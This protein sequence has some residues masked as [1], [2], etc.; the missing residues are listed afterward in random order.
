VS[1]FLAED[2]KVAVDQLRN[3]CRLHDLEMLDE[4]EAQHYSSNLQ[5]AI[6]KF[7][8]DQRIRLLCTPLVTVGHDK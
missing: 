2:V 6:L 4:V 5:K 1:C 7:V 8:G 3:L